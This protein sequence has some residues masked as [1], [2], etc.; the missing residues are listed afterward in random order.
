MKLKAFL[1]GLIVATFVILVF[2]IL[3]VKVNNFLGLSIIRNT[4][5]LFIG[6]LLAILGIGL[7]FYCT[8]IFSK[9]GKG[10]PVP[11]EPPKKFV[12]SGIYSY[13]RNPIYVGYVLIFFSYFFIFG[14][15]GLLLYPF[16]GI[17]V[18]HFYIILIEEKALR[19][20]FGKAYEDYLK[21]VPRW[22]PRLQ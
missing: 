5:F 20:R 12:Y 10:T 17:I 22:I 2:P 14:H 1:F 8:F 15:S 11:I 4:P 18:L 6:I 9:V 16:I 7:F 13:V 21:K 3:L 19:R